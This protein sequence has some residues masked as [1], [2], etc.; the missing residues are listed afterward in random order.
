MPEKQHAP[1]LLTVTAGR[2]RVQFFWQDDRYAHRI[3]V[4]HQQQWRPVLLSKEGTPE[5]HWPPS[6]VFQQATPA[7]GLT[8]DPQ[9]LLV[10]M[11]GRSHWSAAVHSQELSQSPQGLKS[12]LV[13][14]VACRIKIPPRF[15]GSHYVRP[16]LAQSAPVPQLTS[17]AIAEQPAS[18]IHTHPANLDGWV[19]TPSREVAQIS[20]PATL[21]WQYLWVEPDENGDR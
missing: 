16:P 11:A 1:S 21:R 2:L 17:Q 14:D 7:F 15:L 3:E 10:G 8:G 6:P 12:G 19:I 18:S 20:L 5:E 4:R 9:V 13:F